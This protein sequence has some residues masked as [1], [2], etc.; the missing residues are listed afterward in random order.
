MRSERNALAE[1]AADAI[2]RLH[3]SFQDEEQLYL[4][5]DFCAGGDL[6]SL[7]I[8]EDVLP[9][10][11][12]RQYAAEAVAAVA[13]VHALGYIHRDLKPGEGGRGGA[14][15]CIPDHCRCRCYRCRCHPRQLPS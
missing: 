9:E 3:Y 10:A 13:A 5:M 14:L 12:V 1:S 4:V 6:M 11:W 7:L 2:V 8:R 15:C